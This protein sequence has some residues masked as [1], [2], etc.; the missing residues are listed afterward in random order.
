LIL[1]T[2]PDNSVLKSTAEWKSQLLPRKKTTWFKNCR[3][4]WLGLQKRTPNGKPNV[5]TLNQS[6]PPYSKH[7]KNQASKI[8]ILQRSVN[9]STSLKPNSTM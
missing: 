7:N 4:K 2:L 3:I 8:K 5:P 1:N 6:W 9:S